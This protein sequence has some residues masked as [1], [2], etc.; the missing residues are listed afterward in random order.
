MSIKLPKVFLD[1]GNPEE[2]KKAK[3]LLGF[4]DGQTTNPT[5]ICK[6][7]EA[8]SYLNKGKKLTQKELL[9]FY[10]QVVLEIRKIISGSISVEVYADWETKTSDLLNQAE[11]LSSWARNLHIKFPSIPQAINAGR[12]FAQKG[13]LCN[14]TLV[15][16]EI[17]AASVYSALSPISANSNLPGKHFISPFL[18]RWDDR[19]YMGLSLIKNIKKLYKKFDR[20]NHFKKPPVEILSASIRNLHHF[21]G[22]IF[23]GTDILTVPL[24][25]IQE[26][27]EEEK[28]IPDVNYRID[29]HGLKSLVYQDLP[30]QK[31][32][33]KYKIEK[34]GNS[35]LS[36]GLKKFLSD[37]K[38]LLE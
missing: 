14:M 18:G 13:G 19:G 35:L 3:A 7:P 33:A 10:K 20:L 28:W 22:S 8:A 36:E 4:L 17:Q 27:I 2:T 24:K 29:S 12:Q 31:D 5:L 11:E 21:Y 1:S 37:W 6:H 16:D 15:F 30:Y 38:S 25:I 34:E 26:W 9:N 23:L 32:Y